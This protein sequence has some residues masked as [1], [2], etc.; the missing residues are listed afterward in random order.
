MAAWGHDNARCSLPIPAVENEAVDAAQVAVTLGIIH[1]IA[2]DEIIGDVESD[3]YSA[4]AEPM[5]WTAAGDILY[6]PPSSAPR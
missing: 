2:D 1:P 4:T 6:K 5:G 3:R